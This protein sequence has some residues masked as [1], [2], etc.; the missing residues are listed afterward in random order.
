MQAEVQVDK[1]ESTETR[2]GN[3]RFVLRDSEGNEYTTFRPR[4]GTEAAKYEGRRARIEYHEE[5]RNGFRNVYLDGIEPAP[6]AGEGGDGDD[7]EDVEEAAW[8][9]A[10]EA[11]PWLV[12]EPDKR[13]EPDEL[14]EKLKP[15][16]ERVAADI[17]D[18]E[19]RDEGSD[20]PRSG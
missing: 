3:R 20:R 19:P 1:V 10:V 13:V 17:S 15:F 5:E 7:G 6:A 12:G 2:N 4:I 11:A 16:Q 9:T 14:F 18:D 8:R